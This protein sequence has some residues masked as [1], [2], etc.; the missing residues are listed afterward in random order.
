V[1]HI[2]TSEASFSWLP[3]RHLEAA[4]LDG[5]RTLKLKTLELIKWG[6]DYRWVAEAEL[7][8]HPDAKAPYS[9]IRIR[10]KGRNEIEALSRVIDKVKKRGLWDF[11]KSRMA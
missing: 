6:R 3:K 2:I 8:P 9:G 11:A 4:F 5:E 10:R 7:V 1:K